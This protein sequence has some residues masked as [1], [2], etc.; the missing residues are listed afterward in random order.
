[1]PKVRFV[2]DKPPIQVERGDNLMRSL[3]NAKLPVASSCHGQGVCS[4]CKVQV[5]EGAKNLTPESR[6]EVDLKIRNGIGS[7]WR[8][9]CQTSILD[10][11]TIDTPYW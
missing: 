6:L 9:S 5:I 10:D 4:K 8:I 3:L 2:K 1:M 11:V 7:V